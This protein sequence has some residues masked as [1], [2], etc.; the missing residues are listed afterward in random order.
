M[1]DKRKN[2]NH[3]QQQYTIRERFEHLAKEPNRIQHKQRN[4]NSNDRLNCSLDTAID[5][6]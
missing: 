6:K 4:K 5:E 2:W 3:K 1:R